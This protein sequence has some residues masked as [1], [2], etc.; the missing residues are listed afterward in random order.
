VPEGQ[1]LPADVVR[2]LNR[3]LE[4]RRQELR[5]IAIRSGKLPPDEVVS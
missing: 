2:E 5:P 4:R 3:M 1:P